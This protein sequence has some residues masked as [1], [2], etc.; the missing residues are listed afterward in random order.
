VPPVTRVKRNIAANLA[1]R[2][3]AILLSF[4]L[5]PVYIRYLGVE[6]YGLIGFYLTLTAVATVVDPGFGTT[7]TREFARLGGGTPE[8]APATVP[9]PGTPAT[10]P[11]RP[12]DLL[13]TLEVLTLA[14]AV[15]IALISLHCRANAAACQAKK[16]RMSL[17]TKASTS[18]EPMPRSVAPMARIALSVTWC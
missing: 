1:G 9:A 2:G 10:T 15:A 13:R 14:I 18:S 3:W 6:A 11:R 7:L 5:I 16:S 12:A 4:A 8:P 17:A